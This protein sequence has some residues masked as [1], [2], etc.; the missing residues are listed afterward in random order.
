MHDHLA[1]VHR[2]NEK[3]PD[4]KKFNNDKQSA[5]QRG[6]TFNLTQEEHKRLIEQPCYYCGD[7]PDPVNGIDRMD[8]TKGYESDNTVPCC[9]PCNLMKK[10]MH[11]DEFIQRIGRIYTNLEAA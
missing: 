11:I 1:A 10:T 3:Y 2:Y 8:N 5:K 9:W 7:L 4:R 6:L